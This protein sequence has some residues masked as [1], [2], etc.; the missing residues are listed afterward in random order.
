MLML[1]SRLR[2]PVEA[3]ALRSEREGVV[4]ASR[5]VMLLRGALRDTEAPSLAGVVRQGGRGRVDAGEETMAEGE[6][7]ARFRGG[8]Q[9]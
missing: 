2:R 3:G 6:V 1:A 9:I 8:K 4:A 7:E 5:G